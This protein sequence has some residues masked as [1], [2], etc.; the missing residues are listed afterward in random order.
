MNPGKIRAVWPILIFLI[1]SVYSGAQ[2]VIITSIHQSGSLTF[3]EVT[4]A[5]QYQVDWTTN[6]A[7]GLWNTSSPPG[8]AFIPATGIGS[9]TVTVGV[10]QA[11]SYFR[12]L[13]ISLS[14][15][16]PP[17]MV[18]IPAGSF[19][20][21]NATN[22]FS[23]G[24]GSTDE[25]PQHTVNI[26]AFMMDR[27]EV[28]KAL[29]D[30]VAQWASLHGYDLADIH[31]NGKGPDHPVQSI[32]WYEA[33]KW[34]NARS[35]KEFLTPCYTITGAVYRTDAFTT[36]TC[37][38]AAN[39]YRL[40]TE[41]EWEM[42]ARGGTANTRFPWSDVNTIDQTRANYFSYWISGAPFYSYDIS[43]TSG[44]IGAYAIGDYPFTSPVGTFSANG[45]GL[46][47]MAG[48]IWEWCWD[49]YDPAYYA[50]SPGTDPTGPA[51]GTL[52]VQRGSSWGYYANGARVADRDADFPLNEGFYDVGFRSVRRP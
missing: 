3:A 49:W 33:V 9:R 6:L 10:T 8:V 47:D 51:S 27:Y 48:N 41:A 1:T 40:P 38:F 22:V 29:W 52:R 30:N 36:I 50:S 25:L 45:Y 34:C 39:G 43:G 23:P 26:S 20:M 35:E 16:I 11:A 24:E 15:S 31:G 13:S 44:F 18:S 37:N 2:E 32:N 42:A 28:T 14:S 46:H 5:Q 17:D 19:V 21:G 4:N 12:V 7:S